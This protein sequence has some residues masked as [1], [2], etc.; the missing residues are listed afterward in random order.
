MQCNDDVGVG[1]AIGWGCSDLSAKLHESSKSR[2]WRHLEYW[3][4][5]SCLEAVVGSTLFVFL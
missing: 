1:V 3:V 2:Y 5:E 4:A